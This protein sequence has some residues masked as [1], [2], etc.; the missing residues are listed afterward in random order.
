[1]VQNQWLS[2]AVIR[3]RLAHLPLTDSLLA[4]LAHP[5]ARRR[6]ERSTRESDLRGHLI[7]EISLDEKQMETDKQDDP[8]FKVTSAELQA[9]GIKDFQLHYAIETLRRAA[10][11]TQ[12]ARR[13]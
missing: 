2:P 3:E 8:R 1:M 4:L 6:A 9:K 13:P 10:P 7:N 5:D 12:V 11:A